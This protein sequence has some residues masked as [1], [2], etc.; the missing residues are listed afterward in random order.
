MLLPI[1]SIAYKIIVHLQILH[2]FS[3]KSNQSEEMY[4]DFFRNK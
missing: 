2:L 4:D 3:K 1:G